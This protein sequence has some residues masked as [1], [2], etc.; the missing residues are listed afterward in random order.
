[1]EQIKCV[2]AETA[3]TFKN[4][5]II[6]NVNFSSD[7]VLQFGS[8]QILKKKLVRQLILLIKNVAVIVD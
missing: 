3:L 1:M 4:I 6:E 8:Q 2:W 5:L 7:L